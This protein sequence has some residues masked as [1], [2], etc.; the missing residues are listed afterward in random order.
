MFILE[1]ILSDSIHKNTELDTESISDKA[2]IY[3]K[4]NLNKY[5]LTV[6]VLI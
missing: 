4:S 6:R 2:K 1:E 5:V 3:T